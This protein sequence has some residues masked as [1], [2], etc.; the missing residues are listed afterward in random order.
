MTAK[1]RILSLLNDGT[2]RTVIAIATGLGLPVAAT[3]RNL[4]QLRT[5]NAVFC[6]TLQGGNKYFRPVVQ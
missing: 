3:R 4:N 6:D 1:E 5:N 2:P